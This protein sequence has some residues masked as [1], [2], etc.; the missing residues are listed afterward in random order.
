MNLYYLLLF[1]LFC[2]ASGF[3]VVQTGKSSVRAYVFSEDGLV[4]G[5]IFGDLSEIR[6][7]LYLYGHLLYEKQKNK[8]ILSEK[9]KLISQ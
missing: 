5:V 1:F 8:K 7:L 9:H 6:S 4:S 3:Q 2:Q